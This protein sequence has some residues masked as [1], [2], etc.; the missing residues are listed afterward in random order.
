MAANKEAFTTKFT[1]NKTALEP[2]AIFPTKKLRNLIAG[3]ITKKLK[4][5][6]AQQ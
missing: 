4:A 5:Q 3:H 1:E 6:A 2:L